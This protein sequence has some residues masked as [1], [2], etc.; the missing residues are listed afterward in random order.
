MLVRNWWPGCCE[1]WRQYVPYFTNWPSNQPGIQRLAGAELRART[2][3][4]FK[5]ASQQ[6]R[7]IED[8]IELLKSILEEEYHSN[9][10]VD[11]LDNVDSSHEK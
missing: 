11:I 6:H 1:F 3:K 2:I 8:R 5:E 4:N 7:N 9:M 10:N